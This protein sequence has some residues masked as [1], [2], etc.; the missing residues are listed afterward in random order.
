MSKAHFRTGFPL[1]AVFFELKQCWK[2]L[3]IEDRDFRGFLEVLFACFLCS[4]GI[5]ELN[6][7][8]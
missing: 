4:E 3:A 7:Q 5:R 6:N 2:A 1:K 8:A